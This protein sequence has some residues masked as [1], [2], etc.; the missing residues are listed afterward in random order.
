MPLDNVLKAVLDAIAES[1]N[2]IAGQLIT[3]T[4]DR[5][6]VHGQDG[7]TV[8][9]GSPTV[10]TS[11]VDVFTADDVGMGFD[12][13]RP[14]DGVPT[15]N[16]GSYVISAFTDAKNVVCERIDG[17]PAAFV[18]QAP[19]RWRFT[20]LK[21]EATLRFPVND[22]A[23]SLWVGEEP[24]RIP[25]AA[26]V[27]VPGAQEFRG[28]GPHRVS[29][30]GTILAASN[31]VIT[32]GVF[33][34][35]DDVG[36]ALWVF[37]RATPNG[38]E[39][40]RR[41]VSV[42]GD[43]QSCVVS[44][45]VFSATE[46]ADARFAVKDYSTPR[47]HLTGRIPNRPTALE[48]IR[49]LS[50]VVD[51]SQSYS[52]LDKLRR[53]LLVEYAT[54][55]EL[56]RIGRNLGSS[57]LPGMGDEVYRCILQTEPYLPKSTIYGIELILE[58]LFPGGGASV[59]EDLI[60]FPNTVFIL[61]PAVS[62][63]TAVFEGKTFLAPTGK[64]VTPP[65]DPALGGAAFGRKGREKQT[66]STTT[67]VTVGHEPTTIS[68]VL[69]VP[70][71]DAYNNGQ[72]PTGNGY[73]YVDESD[74]GTIESDVFTGAALIGGELVLSQTV[75]AAPSD[76]G[77]RAEIATTGSTVHGS[78][79]EV[80]TWFMKQGSTVN[81]FP[82][83]LRYEDAGRVY[84]VFWNETTVRITDDPNNAGVL[85]DKPHGLDLSVLRWHRFRLRR[86]TKN[87]RSTMTVL[88]NEHPVF[89][90]VPLEKFPV[91][92]NNKQSFGY[93]FQSGASQNWIAYWHDMSLREVS[94][95]NHANIKRQDGSF[96]GADNVLTTGVA[97]F[98]VGDTGKRVRL[99][100]PGTGGAVARK[101]LGVWDATYLSSTTL[102]LT[103]RLTDAIATARTVSGS[104]FIELPGEGGLF[105]GDDVGKEVEIV[106]STVVPSNDGPRVVL[107]V[108]TPTKLRVDGA[109]FQN[110]ASLQIRFNP[111]NG[112]TGRFV[113]TT[114]VEWELVGV[115]TNAGAVVTVR[116][117]FPAASTDLELSYTTIFSAHILRNE[118][119]RNEGSGGSA[120]NIFYPFYLFDV[121]QATRA[122]MDSIT[123]AGVIPEF[124]R[125]F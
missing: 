4:R 15:G 71:L 67:T 72:P 31:V 64:D 86:D 103:G 14:F 121:D 24:E 50:T 19:V 38:N 75:K 9:A 51:A 110:E 82:W 46:T 85:D 36:R 62:A 96:T 23:Q 58:C 70:L 116:D 17:V 27:L 68:E 25:Y 106:G 56:D 124:E 100:T 89:Q 32:P 29:V 83:G 107:Q 7:A 39:G 74:A 30:Q 42:L 99:W 66:S 114:G 63:G 11:L 108:V 95:R 43:G 112:V 77:G 69:R 73:T 76:D 60:N 120:P 61:I 47:G 2:E 88:I 48:P 18:T 118:F 13:I 84:G 54:E 34:D 94:G 35:G 93:W 97:S 3:R 16:E 1:D 117:P 55:E 98:V 5:A 52:A 10:L 105:D 115:A 119:V 79:V 59:Y 44:G 78:S 102:G 81:G 26:R 20:T 28:L 91:S 33:F 41:I 92:A 101:N 57:R 37:E 113:A 122:L 21:V 8:S 45:A 12:I 87:G 104:N 90:G 125:R 80:D 123:A 111:Y 22:K 65:T 53:A 49:E 109:A 6:H 40:P